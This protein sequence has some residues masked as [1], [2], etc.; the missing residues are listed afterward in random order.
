MQILTVAGYKANI[1]RSD[2]GENNGKEPTGSAAEGYKT[3]AKLVIADPVYLKP[4]RP[5][6]RQVQCFLIL[7]GTEE[8]F[9]VLSDTHEY[10][11]LLLLIAFYHQME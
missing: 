11:K 4:G 1:R 2:P 5:R 9:D 3:V 8:R 10:H 6:Q 7:L